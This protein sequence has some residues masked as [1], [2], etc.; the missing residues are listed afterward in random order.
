MQPLV[1]LFLL[2]K[3]I[4]H[5]HDCSFDVIIKV[6][7]QFTIASTLYMLLF[8]L[9]IVLLFGKLERYRGEEG[10]F[11]NGLKTLSSFCRNQ[12]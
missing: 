10:G 8:H 6:L 9:L 2:S 4:N 3:N 12:L 1:S 11:E 7:S 5:V